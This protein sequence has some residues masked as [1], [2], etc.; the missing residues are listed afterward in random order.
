MVWLPA[1]LSAE[2]RD[3][4]VGLGSSCFLLCVLS[5][6]WRQKGRRVVLE[7]KDFTDVGKESSDEGGWLLSTRLETHS[8]CPGPGS[9]K[10]T[11]RVTLH[12]GSGVDI[13]N[14][15]LMTSC[16]TKLQR[17]GHCGPFGWVQSPLKKPIVSRH[18]NLK[19]SSPKDITLLTRISFQLQHSGCL[20]V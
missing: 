12:P 6:V 15:W 11:I 13:P 18:E 14:F 16:V 3:L 19:A 20:Q 10:S 9:R 17:D 4:V 1:H 5:G 2:P 8:P 7:A